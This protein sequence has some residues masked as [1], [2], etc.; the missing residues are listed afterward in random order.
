MRRF[1]NAGGGGANSLPCP[2]PRVKKDSKIYS[3]GGRMELTAGDVAE[4]ARDIGVD[5]LVLF[6][7][8]QSQYEN[9]IHAKAECPA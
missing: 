6:R 2:T 7:R 3:N 8:L 1:K 9:F 4:I 5:P